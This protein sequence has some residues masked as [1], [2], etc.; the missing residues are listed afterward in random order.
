MFTFSFFY[1]DSFSN[2]LFNKLC[3]PFRL[4]VALVKMVKKCSCAP[5]YSTMAV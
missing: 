1:T 4:I 2:L 5:M 3:K